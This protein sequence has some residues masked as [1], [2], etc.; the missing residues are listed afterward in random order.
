M[1]KDT[2]IDNVTPANLDLALRM[3]GIQIDHD[4]LDK[5]IDL[6]E[7]LEAHGD[8]TSIMQIAGVQAKW[9]EVEF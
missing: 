2:S 8:N 1:A 9:G 5:I 4:T 6:V 7:L 3:S